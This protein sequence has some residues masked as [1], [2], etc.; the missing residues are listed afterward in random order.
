MTVKADLRDRPD[1]ATSVMKDELRQMKT[2]KV[3][4]GVKIANL[5]AQQNG[6]VIPSSMFLK[7]SYLA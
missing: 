4:H 2:K 6:A 7:D 3:W 5:T 1:K